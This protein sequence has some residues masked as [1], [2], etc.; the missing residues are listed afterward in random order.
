MTKPTTEE[1]N[2]AIAAMLGWELVK[3]PISGFFMKARGKQFG[4]LF[5]LRQEWF[6][7]AMSDE[8]FIIPERMMFHSDAN[9]QFEA[10]DWIEKQ[11]DLYGRKGY[12]GVRIGRWMKEY[13]CIIELYARTGDKSHNIEVKANYS[14]GKDRKEAI[15]EALYQFSQYLKSQK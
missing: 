11:E 8:Y 6:L 14:K 2:V 12:Y 15:F 13:S 5:E 3:H 4:H 1:M 7:R 10:I 9:W